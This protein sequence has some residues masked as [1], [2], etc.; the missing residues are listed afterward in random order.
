MG[1]IVSQLCAEVSLPRM[2]KV[3]QIFD[4]GRIEKEDISKAVFAE[5]SRP[6][7]GTP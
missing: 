3:N 5:L 7:L 4:R 1:G 2:L 6:E